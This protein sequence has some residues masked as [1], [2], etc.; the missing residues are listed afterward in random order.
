MERILGYSKVGKNGTEFYFM[1]VEKDEASNRFYIKDYQF[2]PG[3]SIQE[4]ESHTID[5]G[6]DAL[7][8]SLDR[9]D[10]F[11]VIGD[12]TRRARN[13]GNSVQVFSSEIFEKVYNFTVE[14][15]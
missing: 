14:D 15:R 10:N 9:D 5:L 8:T 7:V 6:P 13:T 3:L 12:T 1:T 11:I 4:I 2:F